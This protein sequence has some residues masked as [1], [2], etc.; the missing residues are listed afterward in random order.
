MRS[1]PVRERWIRVDADRYDEPE[2][3]GLEV[4]V[5]VFISPYAIPD[6]V[7]GTYDNERKRFVVQFNY[8]V[9]EPWSLMETNQPV[10]V[11]VGKHSRRVVG[12][13]IDVDGIGASAVTVRLDR[14]YEAAEG[15]IRD[16]GQRIGGR[17][18]NH[19]VTRQVLKDHRDSL[20]RDLALA[21]AE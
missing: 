20:F 9:D 6:S 7:R 17:L 19:Y 2:E 13:E 12:L 15:A 5:G 4:E 18:H 21:G 11:R 10:A 1:E 16:V 3:V 14:L 8:M